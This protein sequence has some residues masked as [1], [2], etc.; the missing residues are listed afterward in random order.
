MDALWSVSVACILLS[1]VAIYIYHSGVAWLLYLK[2]WNQN[3]VLF[4]VD[5]RVK[6]NFTD[7]EKTM[8]A[9]SSLII[10]VFIL[11]IILAAAIARSSAT[12]SHPK[13][14]FEVRIQSV[15]FTIKTL[16]R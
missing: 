9:I 12:D 3:M 11:E 8:L 16:F 4:V 5:E 13:Q 15:S 2:Y 14:A 7:K 10:I 1:L 6:I